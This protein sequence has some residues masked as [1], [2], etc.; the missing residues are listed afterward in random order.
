VRL[1]RWAWIWAVDFADEWAGRGAIGDRESRLR[2][3]G[4]VTMYPGSACI[5]EGKR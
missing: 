4:L 3:G 5:A 1:I 2:E